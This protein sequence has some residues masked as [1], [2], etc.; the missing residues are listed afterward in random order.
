MNFSYAFFSPFQPK[1]L[2]MMNSFHCGKRHVITK[3]KWFQHKIFSEIRKNQLQNQSAATLFSVCQ[4]DVWSK[5]GSF[6]ERFFLYRTRIKKRSNK[7]NF[8]FVFLKW[9]YGGCREK[10]MG[11]KLQ[12]R[13]WTQAVLHLF[14]SFG[15]CNRFLSL[16]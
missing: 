4:F 8:N 1:S 12:S 6:S 3:V 2:R 9:K 13:H 7:K 14:H 15:A 10:H 5:I 16:P 11:K